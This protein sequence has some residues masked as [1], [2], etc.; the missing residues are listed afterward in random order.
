MLTIVNNRL[1]FKNVYH[2]NE[3]IARFTRSQA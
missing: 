3:D 1:D 2:L